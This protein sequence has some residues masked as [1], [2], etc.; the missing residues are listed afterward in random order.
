MLKWKNNEYNIN[1]A[2]ITLGI[3]EFDCI[4]G[5]VYKDG[6]FQYSIWLSVPGSDSRAVITVTKIRGHLP[7]AKAKVEEIIDKI[8]KSATA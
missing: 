1:E 5:R 4:P 7:D 3:L 8:M 6:T 2:K